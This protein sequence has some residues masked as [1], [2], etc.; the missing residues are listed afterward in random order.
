MRKDVKRIRELSFIY[1][2]RARRA[3]VAYGEST[4]H[5]LN[6]AADYWRK[7]Y[8][9]LICESDAYFSLYMRMSLR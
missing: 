8:E 6:W 5:R 9:R 3:E 4:I 2:E 1:R 7:V